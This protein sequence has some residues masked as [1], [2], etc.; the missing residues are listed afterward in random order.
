M[1]SMSQYSHYF[2]AVMF[3]MSQ[4]VSAELQA[5]D[6]GLLFFTAG[7]VFNVINVTNVRYQE[8]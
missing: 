3:S 7:T 4:C 5:N 8:N 2:Q 6:G 1:F